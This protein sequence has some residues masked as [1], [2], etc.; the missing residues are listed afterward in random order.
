VHVLGGLTTEYDWPMQISCNRARED[1]MFATRSQNGTIRIWKTQNEVGGTDQNEVGGTDQNEVG[2]TD[3]NALGLS[4]QSSTLPSVLQES[5]QKGQLAELP[6]DTEVE[7]E[8]M[9]TK[10]L[11]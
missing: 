7:G 6:E 5:P 2:G 9:D 11:F 4:V 1:F 8:P 3:Q 10:E